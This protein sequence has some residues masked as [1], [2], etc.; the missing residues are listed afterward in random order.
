MDYE[1]TVAHPESGAAPA[2]RG[3]G[4]SPTPRIARHFAFGLV[5]LSAS[6]AVVYP[7]M[8]KY[9]LYEPGL[10][11]RGGDTGQYV[12]MYQ[13]TPLAQII[14]PFRYRVFTPYMARLVPLPPH[15]LLRYFDITPD[16]IVQY[17]FAVANLLGLALSGMLL[18]ALCESFGLAAPWGML[19]ALLFLTSLTVVNSAGAPMTDAWAYAFL[20]LGL[21]AAIRGSMAWLSLA[22]LVGMFAKETTLLLVP[23]VLLLA[24]PPRAKLMKLAALIPGVVGYAIFRHACSAGGYSFPSDVT[25]AVSDTIWRFRHGPYLWWIA[26]EGAAAFG[27]ILPLAW[28]GALSLR[29]SPRAPLAR[30]SWLV[31]GT[32]IPPLFNAIGIGSG[33]G[34]IWFYSF[35]AMIPLA[36]VGLRRVLDGT[37][38]NGLRLGPAPP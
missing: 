22:S 8:T 9:Q 21:V 34:H 4:G 25:T 30:L 23:A 28:I 6:A 17:H 31:P 10:G 13:G 19:G 18:I 32:L 26:F 38:R 12:A 24:D 33:I 11:G 16:K 29:G 36:L 15:G 5:C 20:L 35:P 7:A 3:T 2:H 14:K 37:G 27:A 1:D